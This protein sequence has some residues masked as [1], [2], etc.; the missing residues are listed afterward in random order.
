M[1]RVYSNNKIYK[2]FRR[3][4]IFYII[5]LVI[6]IL[7]VITDVISTYVINSESIDMVRIMFYMFALL[8][9]LCSR[10][11]K[12][13]KWRK[14]NEDLENEAKNNNDFSKLAALIIYSFSPLII[15]IID[16]FIMICTKGYSPFHWAYYCGCMFPSHLFVY[17][18]D[19]FLIQNCALIKEEWKKNP[20]K[21]IKE[22]AAEKARIEQEKA[23]NQKMDLYQN[24]IKQCGIKFFIKYYGQI[25]R[26]PLRDVTVTENYSSEERE[27][28][29]LA[30]KKIIDSG[31]TVFA[32]SEIL[33][34]YS[35][36]LN[37]NEIMQAKALLEEI[38]K[39]NS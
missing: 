26:L 16:C 10:D 35:D 9:P 24:L 31:L 18:A 36:A 4:R 37:E 5:A 15:L 13:V 25:K 38:E 27:E 29:L 14:A 30:A 7:I 17:I 23:F 19:I 12:N 33:K 2:N 20:P 34:T 32:L 39:S 22:E 21:F 8:I 11:L 3:A 6:A 28:R 1:F